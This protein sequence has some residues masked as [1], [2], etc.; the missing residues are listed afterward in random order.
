MKRF[1]PVVEL[2]STDDVAIGN[3]LLLPQLSYDE[4]NANHEY[5]DWLNSGVPV[6]QL[7][8]I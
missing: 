3:L 4:Y 7:P 2:H 1:Q 6:P 8:P 5:D